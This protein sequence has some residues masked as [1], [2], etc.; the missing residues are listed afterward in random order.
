MQR[1]ARRA[2][3]RCGN[4][5]NRVQCSYKIIDFGVAALLVFE[6]RI[7]PKLNPGMIAK[8][9]AKILIERCQKC[10]CL[11]T[12]I[13]FWVSAVVPDHAK[14]TDAFYSRLMTIKDVKEASILLENVLR[15][16][17]LSTGSLV[18]RVAV[19]WW[20]CEKEGKESNAVKAAKG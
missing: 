3:K 1:I 8:A 12:C 4:C 17:G 6:D 19:M 11:K 5:D 14:L 13:M 20:E 18:H 7:D 15:D 9:G 16:Q 10:P 2:F